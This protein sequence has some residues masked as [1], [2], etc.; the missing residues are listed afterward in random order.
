MNRLEQLLQTN[1]LAFVLKAHAA[2]NPGVK[3]TVH[4][5][6]KL[7]CHKL[8]RAAAGE[9]RRLVINLPPGHLKTFAASV[10]LAGWILAHKPTAKILLL[11]Y[12]QELAD[13]IAFAIREILTSDW[14]MRAFK[15]RLAKNRGRLTDFA[16]TAGG[17]VRSVSIE[18]GVTGQRA[19]YILIDDPIQ[20]KDSENLRQI[21]RVNDLFDDEIWTRLSNPK[22]GVIVLT[23][24][25]VHENDLSGHVL[26]QER[27]KHLKL[28]LVAPRVRKYDLGDGQT[29]HR[30]KGEL[31]R[32]DAY[33]AG[34]IKKA[35]ASKRPGFE[36]LFQQNPGAVSRAR[37]KAEHFRPFYLSALPLGELPMLLSIDPAQKGGQHNS[38]AVIQAWAAWH[39]DY[40]L[41]EQ[42]REHADYRALR[43][44]TR[45]FIV[46]YRPSVVLIEATGQGPSLACDIRVQIGMQVIQITPKASKID[47][48]YAHRRVIRAGRVLLRQDAPWVPEFLDEVTI[49][50]YGKFDD[51][52]DALSQLLAWAEE[53][54]CPPPR[55]ARVNISAIGYSRQPLHAAAPRAQCRGGVLVSGIKWPW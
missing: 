36:T 45:R 18:G 2:K 26:R 29:W 24:H 41:I 3:L 13:K 33:S 21:E 5:F 52:V 25:R 23:A 43:S 34:D 46:K 9:I 44:E 11:S 49:F 38:C 39:G 10:C 50:P 6:V 28:P 1:Y 47:R 32:P 31:L 14:Y 7:L 55:P 16:T 54:P 22:K 15:T 42:W 12:G 37:I 27:W 35:R 19:D 4:P 30:Q 53:N 20:I 40:Y 8:E 17:G 48:L 51:Q